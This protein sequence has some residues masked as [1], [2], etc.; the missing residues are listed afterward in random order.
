MRHG[1]IALLTV[2]DFAES[3]SPSRGWFLQPSEPL[4]RLV[5]R[6]V[7]RRMPMGSLWDW[8]KSRGRANGEP[9]A[10][11]AQQKRGETVRVRKSG[12]RH[13]E[14]AIDKVER[15]WAADGDRADQDYYH[16]PGGGNP[17][18]ADPPKLDGEPLTESP[19]PPRRR[20]GA[21]PGP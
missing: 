11:D 1:R 12:P 18:E 9:V 13:T 5:F 7:R 8:F 6:D 15:K 20:G 4:I 10:E 2:E 21:H 3:T 17:D 14:A 16:M 19:S